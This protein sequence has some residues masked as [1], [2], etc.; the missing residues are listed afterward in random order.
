IHL[1]LAA[2]SPSKHSLKSTDSTSSA[3]FKI[4]FAGGKDNAT[5][6]PG[7]ALP[8]KVSIYSGSDPKQW[9]MNIPTYAEVQYAEVYPGIGIAYRGRSRELEYDF[10]LAPKADPSL[11]R[12]DFEGVDAAQVDAK[13]NLILA[14]RYGKLVQQRP[15][16]YQDI[17]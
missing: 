17:D 13:G 16:A 12:M 5:S 3:E 8:A 4:R 11:V 1:T 14:T 6:K 9:I 2:A 10:L 15:V 7:E